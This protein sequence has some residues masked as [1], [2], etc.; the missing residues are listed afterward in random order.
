MLDFGVVEAPPGG[1]R[2]PILEKR[3]GLRIGRVAQRGTACFRD[4]T[5][6]Y[7]SPADASTASQC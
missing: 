3:G 4:I 6:L 7:F 5:L 1:R 2:H